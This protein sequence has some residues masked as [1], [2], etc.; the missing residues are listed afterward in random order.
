MKTVKNDVHGQYVESL[1]LLRRLLERFHGLSRAPTS[2]LVISIT[3]NMYL[4]SQRLE[5]F[6]IV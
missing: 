6:Q 1:S 2:R 3:V 4:L 5:C